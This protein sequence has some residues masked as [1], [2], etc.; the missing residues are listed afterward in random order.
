MIGM[1]NRVRRV[2]LDGAL[3]SLTGYWRV[4]GLPVVALVVLESSRGDRGR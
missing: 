4:A 1:M 3:V 2:C